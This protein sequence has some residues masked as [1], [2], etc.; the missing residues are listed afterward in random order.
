MSGVFIQILMTR[1][2]DLITG[3]NLKTARQSS[4]ITNM[5]TSARGANHSTNDAWTQA[6]K[7]TARPIMGRK[8]LVA[9]LESQEQRGEKSAKS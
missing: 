8:S 1:T 9:A 4:L 5:E 7:K 2:L 6:G 3:S